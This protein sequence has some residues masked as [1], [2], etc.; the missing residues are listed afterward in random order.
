MYI[1]FTDKKT[2]MERNKTTLAH[3]FLNVVDGFCPRAFVSISLE[4]FIEFMSN[5]AF[6]VLSIDIREDARRDQRQ[7]NHSQ[8]NEEL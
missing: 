2:E 5:I 4:T 3:V 6:D 8:N 1:V 7:E